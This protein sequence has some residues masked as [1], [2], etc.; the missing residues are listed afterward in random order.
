MVCHV[1]VKK[2]H[3]YTDMSQ[4][5]MGEIHRELYYYYYFYKFKA[6]LLTNH[7]SQRFGNNIVGKLSILSMWCR[8]DPCECE[9]SG[10]GTAIG[11]KF[12]LTCCAVICP[13]ATGAVHSTVW[14][15]L[16]WVILILSLKRFQ[17]FIDRYEYECPF[18]AS[19]LY[20]IYY[21][22]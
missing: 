15:T 17:I 9:F 13:R 11:L 2:S 5:W 3:I 10:D 20:I 19:C 8:L 14:E 22:C 1:W 4:R 7:S 16:I 6:N 21:E 12:S 18:F